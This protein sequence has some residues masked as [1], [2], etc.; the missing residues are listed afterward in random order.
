MSLIAMLV[1][2][3]LEKCEND[4]FATINMMN[5]YALIAFIVHLIGALFSLVFLAK[6]E[7]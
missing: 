6:E 7:R 4:A 1:A 3:N 5:M 2:L